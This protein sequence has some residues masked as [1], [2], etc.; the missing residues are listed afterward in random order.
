[1]SR[2]VKDSVVFAMEEEQA[3]SFDGLTGLLKP[4][5]FATIRRRELERLLRNQQGMA[6]V[7]FFVDLDKFKT[8]NDV[9]GHKEGDRVLIEVGKILKR[10]LRSIDVVSRLGGDEFGVLGVVNSLEEAKELAERLRASVEKAE[11]RVTL[12]IGIS[13]SKPNGMRAT[14]KDDASV[15]N[16]LNEEE[17]RLASESDEAALVAKHGSNRNAVCVFSE[18]SADEKVFAARMSALAAKKRAEESDAEKALVA[19]RAALAAKER[20]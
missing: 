16:W 5:V 19:E 11:L 18:L 9:H 7:Q 4:E 3:S 8:V 10:E 1:M 20:E 14:L 6:L 2:H 17:V 13:V 12:S 15:S